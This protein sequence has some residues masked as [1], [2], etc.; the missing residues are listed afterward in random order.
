M[1]WHGECA[2]QE[3]EKM[4]MSPLSQYIKLWRQLVNYDIT[5]HSNVRAGLQWTMTMPCDKLE[6]YRRLQT[7]AQTSVNECHIL[8]G[9]EQFHVQTTKKWHQSLNNLPPLWL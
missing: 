5:R 7:R 6:Q 4:T 8:L 3:S 9:V 1:I 2:K